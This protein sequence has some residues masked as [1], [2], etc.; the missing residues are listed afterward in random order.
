MDSKFLPS[1]VK[2]LQATSLW[3]NNRVILREFKHFRV[4]AI[5]A[6]VFSALAASF[7]G[8]GLGFLLVF[9]QSLTTPGS[10]PVKTGIEW[11]DILILGINGSATERLYRISALIVV[12]TCMRASFNYIGQICIQFSEISLV[13]NLRKRIFQQL[14][15]QTLSYFSHKKSGELVNILTSE[16]ERIRQIFGGLAFLITRGFTLIVY[17]ISLFI[18]SWKLTIVS[19][20]LF[21]LLAVG[22][23]TL[24]K[25]IRERSF[26]ITSANDNFTARVLE[27]IEGIRTIHAFSTQEFERNRYY[28][29]SEKIV[30]TWKS[31]YWISLIVKPLAESISTLILISMIIVALTTG[32]MK[33][34]ALLTFFFVLFRIIPM[35]QDLNGVIAFLSTQAGAVEN[36]KDLLKT[37]DKIYFQ[38]GALRFPGFKR[39]IDLVSVDFD[40][41]LNQRV[42]HNIT[43]SIKQGQMTALI[44]S[45]GAG[46]TTL[47]DLIPR[48]HDATD[49]YIYIDEVDI[50]KFDINSLRSKI[51]VVS[52]NTFIFNTSVWNNIAYGTP[53][54]TATEIKEAARLA[55]ALEFILEMPTG[56]DTQLGD[57]GVRLSGGQRQRIAIARALLKN[58]EI[59]ILD[60]ATSALDSVSERLIQ[61]SLEKLSVGRTVIAI[62]HRLSTIAK[63]DKVV[64][65]EQGKIVEQG[66]YQELLQQRGKFWQY[67]QIQN[68]VR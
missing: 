66:A 26:A 30:N 41:S 25:Q 55:N 16:M 36:I 27:F 29:A 52:Q 47:A 59:L 58:P 48:F 7:E 46:K 54:A 44:G 22:L 14:E 50:R 5:L 68:E 49:G 19:I 9:L 12:T 61:E 37:D 62:A 24:N 11:F 17:S 32:L 35:T 34:S 33:V 45:S 64:V 1:T 18:L 51:A 40:Y 4:V 2:I 67:Y 21:S 23:S 65:L 3:Q 56:F 43:L 63:A 6:I 8:F 57:R 60:E 15:A 42:L 38:N 31:V 28:Q 39:S 20:L 53:T 13:D 10:E